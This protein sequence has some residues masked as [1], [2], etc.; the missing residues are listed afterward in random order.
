MPAVIYRCMFRC[1]CGD[2]FVIR[3]DDP[4]HLHGMRLTCTGCGLLLG[5]VVISDVDEG[6]S[7][8][9]AP[10]DQ[11]MAALRQHSEQ[12]TSPSSRP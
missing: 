7:L 3:T 9:L 4:F 6:Y 1:L 12:P 10:H 2:T 11:L 5:K 8:R